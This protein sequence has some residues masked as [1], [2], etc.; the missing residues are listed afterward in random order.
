MQA[1]ITALNRLTRQGHILNNFVHLLEGKSEYC[2][3]VTHEISRSQ[4]LIL[5]CLRRLV[6][7]HLLRVKQ[8]NAWLLSVNV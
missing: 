5:V 2:F 7:C 8:K 6:Y 1:Y 4:T 3:H